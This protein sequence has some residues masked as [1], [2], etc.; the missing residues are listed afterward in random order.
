VEEVRSMAEYEAARGMPAASEIVF[1]IAARP[2]LFDR[3][4]PSAVHVRTSPEE[5][6]VVH[7]KT[8]VAGG[9]H[10]VEGLF[11]AQ[12]DQR[13]LE[14]G[15]RGDDRYAGWLQVAESGAGS[16]EV[17]VHLSIRDDE[18]VV[19]SDFDIEQ[20][21]RDALDQLNEDV[22]ARVGGTSQG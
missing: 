16:S 8:R 14:W 6:P 18:P 3:W 12:P 7:A 15:S 2:D 13:R 9:P 19:D 17:T 21:L 5:L 4:I 22:T 1:D 10:E 11:R 20:A